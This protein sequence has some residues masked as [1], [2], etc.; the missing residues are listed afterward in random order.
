LEPIPDPSVDAALQAA[1]GRLKGRPL[2]GVIGSLG[3]RGDT[4]SV[5]LLAKFLQDADT[6]TA[7]T[8]ARALGKIGSLEASR[9]LQQALAK[10]S[11]DRRLAIADGYLGCAEALLAAGN[12]AAAAEIYK[13]VSQAE[14]PQHFRLAAVQG[15]LL[16]QQ[17]EAAP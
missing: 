7:A 8:A 2:V 10:S 1:A 13:N 6:Q 3:V 12:R 4:K 14:L 11:P 15:A 16:V 17:S 9:V 5:A